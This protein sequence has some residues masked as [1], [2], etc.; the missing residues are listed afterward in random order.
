MSDKDIQMSYFYANMLFYLEMT[1]IFIIYVKF[2]VAIYAL[3]PPI[4]LA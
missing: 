3:F 4:F 1:C 2:V